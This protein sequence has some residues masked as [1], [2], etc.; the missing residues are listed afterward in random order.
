MPVRARLVTSIVEDVVGAQ[1]WDNSR[2]HECQSMPTE[3]YY[4]TDDAAN[5]LYERIIDRIDWNRVMLEASSRH[6]DLVRA[7]AHGPA[8]ADLAD[9]FDDIIC[10]DCIREALLCDDTVPRHDPKPAPR[11]DTGQDWAGE[12]AEMRGLHGKSKR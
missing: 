9:M 1:W 3:D 2:G 11:V 6:F 4:R 5:V 12:F 7:K 8:G 10:P